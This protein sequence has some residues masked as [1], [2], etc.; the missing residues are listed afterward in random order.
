MI[1]GTKGNRLAAREKEIL[2]WLAKGKSA[3]EAGI[4]LNISVCTV[5]VHIQNIK[6][7]LDASNIPHAIAKA[8]DEGILQPAPDSFMLRPK[9]KSWR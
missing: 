3:P 1:C 2:S 9:S 8:F 6:R 7:K 4:I 5:R